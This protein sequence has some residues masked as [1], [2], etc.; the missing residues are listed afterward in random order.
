MFTTTK[1]IPPN[2][3]T[4]SSVT[5][6]QNG[7]TINFIQSPSDSSITSY[8]YASSTDGITYSSY[9]TSNWTS[10]T[11]F[12]VTGLYSD[13]TYYFKIIAN[14]GT[15]SNASN[16][17]DGVIISIYGPNAPTITRITSHNQKATINFTQT[18]SNSNIINYVY[19]Y[20]TNNSSTFTDFTLC[21]PATTTTPLT[22]TGLTNRAVIS[23]RIRSFDGIFY[24]K[25]SN[26]YYNQFMYTS[27]PMVC[28]K[29]TTKILT[30]NGYI[31]IRNLKKGD[32]V[33]TFGHGLKP[34]TV[35]KKQEII[36][37]VNESKIPDQLYKYNREKSGYNE[38]T[39]DL[40][41]TGRHS[42]LVDNFAS[43]TQKEKVIKM[44]GSI[45]KTDNK[46][47]LPACVDDNSRVYEISGKHT[48][49]NLALQSDNENSLYGIYAN[50]LLVESCS[51]KYLKNITSMEN[52]E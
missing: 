10:G 25:N 30:N 7:A 52:I 6:S 45:I 31:A 12:T 48:V 49:Y 1:L 18:P 9:T 4:I 47:H 8:K 14:N 43:E 2:A 23:Y 33:E 41:V 16:A 50:G 5:L 21:S 27:E 40:I 28:F 24:S 32:L 19:S 20:K 13:L 46:Y 42:I 38:L 17:S 26:T 51:E 37:N 34:I 36:Y 22:I 15:D 11:N 3:P 29:D 44:S 35:I 39:E